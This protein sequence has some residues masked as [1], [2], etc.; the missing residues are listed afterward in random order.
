MMICMTNVG[1][2]E[3]PLPDTSP[4]IIERCSII[5]TLE[6]FTSCS[7]CLDLANSISTRSELDSE[8][9]VERLT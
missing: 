9:C 1:D 7:A 8:R 3:G 6:S 5:V 4:D 2:F